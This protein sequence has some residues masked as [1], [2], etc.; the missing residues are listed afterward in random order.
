MSQTSK[1][2]I[3]EKK[4]GKKYGFGN[5]SRISGFEHSLGVLKKKK[6]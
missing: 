4:K 5:T 1:N 2:Q 6:L 3:W